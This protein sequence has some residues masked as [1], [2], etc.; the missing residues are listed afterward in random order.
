MTN[1]TPE[2]TAFCVCLLHLDSAGVLLV[3][4]AIAGKSVDLRMT[5]DFKG[6]GGSFVTRR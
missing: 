1:G 4:H 6:R 2:D 5:L 3:G